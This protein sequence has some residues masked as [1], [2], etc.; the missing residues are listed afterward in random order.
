M[1]NK[2]AENFS[3]W[4][5]EVVKG[6]DL[7]ENSQVRGCMVIKPYGYALWENIQ[8]TLD[9]KIKETGC[10]NAYFPLFIPKSFLSKEAEHVKGFAKECAIVTHYRLKET[11]D[12]KGVEVDPES[13]LAEELIVRPT[14]E[15]IINDSFSR[16]ISSWRDLP[17]CINQWANIVRWEMRTR[18]FLRTTEF[19]W[20]EGHTA[21]ATQAEAEEKTLQMLEIY[22]DLLEN[23]L[24]I[25][26]FTGKKSEAEKFPGADT[27]YAIEAMMRD[28]K[29]LQAGTSHNLGQNFSKNFEIKFDDK[30]KETKYVWQTSWGVSTRLIGG[31]VMAHGD[32][33]GLI[34]PPKI[35]PTQ[36]VIVPILGTEKDAEILEKADSLK[37]SLQ[38]E[39]IRVKVD[40]RE[41]HRP[42]FKFNEWELKGVP[43]RVELGPKDLENNSVVVV[44]RDTGEKETVAVEKLAQ[45]VVQKLEEIQKALYQ[46]HKKFTEEN[47]VT[48]KNMEEFKK[49]AK[50]KPQ[51]IRVFW[52]ENSDIEEKIKEETKYTSRTRA[53]D[54]ASAASEGTDFY[55]GK[56]AKEEWFFALAY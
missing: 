22:K 8:K 27:T 52:N 31:L 17:L 13:K 18:L 50:E 26:A 23:Y 6:A 30:D 28:G 25:H 39:T 48:A 3:E 33:K 20:Q 4:Y 12:G 53:K 14:S 21:H 56:P 44:R 32:D 51:Y 34:I 46:S 9:A 38:K 29:A 5:Q 1:V 35:A 24:A 36:V 7:A 45:H 54:T 37:D 42:G 11:T 41:E 43:L 15:T 55:T 40:S 47:T 10:E 49:I 19:L 16:W 2:Q